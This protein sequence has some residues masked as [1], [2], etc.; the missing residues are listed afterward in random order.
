MWDFELNQTSYKLY[1]ISNYRNGKSTW[2]EFFNDI[3]L[4]NT[5]Y[6]LMSI[7]ES[8]HTSINPILN[9]I[10]KLSNVFR[11]ESF[12]RLLLILAPVELRSNIKT[13]LIYLHRLPESIP[14]FNI[15][16][17]TVNKELEME[18]EKL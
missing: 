9:N 10:I 16:E 7:K 1:A 13:I 6:R 18:L 14:E 15:D 11:K 17:I 12:G 8:K 5:I 3:K 2:N 4:F